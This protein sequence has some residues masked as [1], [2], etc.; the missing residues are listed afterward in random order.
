MFLWSTFFI[1]G[2]GDISYKSNLGM[3]PLS[4]SFRKLWVHWVCSVA[5]WQPKLLP[6]SQPNSY[7]LFLSSHFLIINSWVSLLR[8]KPWE[9]KQKLSTSKNRDTGLA[10]GSSPLFPLILFNFEGNTF[11][12]GKR[13]KFQLQRLIINSAE[14]L[15][16][17]GTWFQW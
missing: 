6:V 15:N 11:R 9:T 1:W 14:E 13:I 10:Y 7:A 16:F 12:K 2:G 17:K 4:T 3:W 8:P 5:D